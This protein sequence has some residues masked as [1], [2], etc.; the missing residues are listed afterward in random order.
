[1]AWWLNFGKFCNPGIFFPASVSWPPLVFLWHCSLR[2]IKIFRL[3][4]FT[5]F[6][7]V[8]LPKQILFWNSHGWTP[9]GFRR[10]CSTD[11][12]FIFVAKGLLGLTKCTGVK[13]SDL[14]RLHSLNVQLLYTV[15]LLFICMAFNNPP[16]LHKL[17]CAAH[18]A[19]FTLSVVYLDV[20]SKSE[21]QTWFGPNLIFM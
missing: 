6:F 18:F 10:P 13:T 7:F 5:E 20:L 3:S 16:N 1:M 11:E 9:C 4:V 12:M 17:N 15:D 19:F 8:S 2:Y 21:G 14:K